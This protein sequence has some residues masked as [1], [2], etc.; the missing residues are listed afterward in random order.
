VLSKAP[1]PADPK[2]RKLLDPVGLRLLR[3]LQHDGRASLSDL[4]QRVGLSA[5]A[6]AERLKRLEES[7][8]VRGYRADIDLKR[9]GVSAQAFV[10]LTVPM[11][12]QL[13]QVTAALDEW[14]EVLECHR[15][16]G[17]EC[18]LIRLGLGVV[19]DLDALLDRLRR[20]GRTETSVVLSSPIERRL[21]SA[22]IRSSR[23]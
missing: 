4:G 1:Y 18:Y 16:T 6:V 23:S 7:G 13:E 21:V 9:M 10:R 2:I 15:V 8:V 19:E 11:D 20:F 14:P 22:P 5:P 12:C 17:S 3:E